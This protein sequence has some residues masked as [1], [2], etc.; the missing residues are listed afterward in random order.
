MTFWRRLKLYGFGFAIGMMI[1][2]AM[3]GTRSCVSPNEQ[4]MQ[5]LVYQQFKLSDKAECKLKCLMKNALLLKIEL[6]HFEV[7]Y[8]ASAIHKKPCG[9]YFIEPKKEF[10]GKY[11]Y[12]LIIHDCDTIS[13]IDD[14]NITQTNTCSCQ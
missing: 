13:R 9:E 4:K 12:N 3:F 7:N 10:A 6:R 2:Y 14:I 5:E 1:V 11:N 8:D